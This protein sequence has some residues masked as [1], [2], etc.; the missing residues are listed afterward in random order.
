MLLLDALFFIWPFNAISED[1]L[2][3]SDWAFFLPYT[4]ITSLSCSL[5]VCMLQTE[6]HEERQFCEAS[7]FFG[8][9]EKT[10]F[11]AQ[12]SFS[13]KPP[14]PGQRSAVGVGFGDA[15]PAV[16]DVMLMLVPPF[17]S[18]AL[19]PPSSRRTKHPSP[20]APAAPAAAGGVKGP[21]RHV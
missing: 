12:H 9:V 4:S 2:H 3:S 8:V 13:G 15:D 11:I 5:Q 17:T 20:A 18:S 7:C 16:A 1:I 14:P 21:G 6:P 19:L 10:G